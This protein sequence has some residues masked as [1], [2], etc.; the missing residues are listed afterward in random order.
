MKLS[1]HRPVFA[2]FILNFD[3]HERENI[4]QVKGLEREARRRSIQR[5][6]DQL[7]PAKIYQVQ[8]VDDAQEKGLQ[9]SSVT[10]GNQDN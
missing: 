5:K 8:P 6:L 2:Q 1:D 3:E 4:K 9:I 7:K 10:F